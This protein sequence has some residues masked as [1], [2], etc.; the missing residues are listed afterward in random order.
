MRC[1]FFVDAELDVDSSPE[2]SNIGGLISVF[3]SGR[4]MSQSRS[5]HKMTDAMAMPAGIHGEM[6][7]VTD[8][9]NEAISSAT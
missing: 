9:T 5:R 4:G 3:K 1:D 7:M 2:V 8:A 6:S